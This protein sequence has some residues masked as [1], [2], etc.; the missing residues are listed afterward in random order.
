MVNDTNIYVEKSKLVKEYL[1]PLLMRLY[2]E[3][4]E[5]QYERTKAGIELVH[6][7]YYQDPI[8]HVADHCIESVNVTADSLIALVS[9][10]I[11]AVRWR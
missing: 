4:D 9:D 8:I 5:V 6:I 3:I 11:A 7:I 2:P 10:V 1:E